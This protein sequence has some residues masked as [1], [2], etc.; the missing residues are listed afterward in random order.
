M[1]TRAVGF[2]AD[3]HHSVSSTRS[4]ANARQKAL[5]VSQMQIVVTFDGCDPPT[6]RTPTLQG[7]PTPSARVSPVYTVIALDYQAMAMP[8]QANRRMYDFFPLG[9]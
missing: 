5:A 7:A 2:L 3:D 6:A 4:K 1:K 8:W 9:V